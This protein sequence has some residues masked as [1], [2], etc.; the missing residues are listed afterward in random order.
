M[1]RVGPIHNQAQALDAFITQHEMTGVAIVS[2]PEEM[3]VNETA[4]LERSLTEDVGVAVDQ[5]Y[6]N[7][8]YPERFSEEEAEKLARVLEITEGP[9]QAAFAQPSPS[10]AGRVPSARSFSGWSAA[11]ACRSGRCPSSSSRGWTCPP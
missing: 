4:A 1:A 10:S 2:L 8:M 9:P 3:P 11:S 7:A 6:M 5:V